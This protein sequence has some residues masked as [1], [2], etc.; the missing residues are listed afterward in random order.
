MRWAILCG[1]LALGTAAIAVADEPVTLHVNPSVSVAP[2]TVGIRVRVP[3]EADNRA[4]EIVLDSENFYRSSRLELDGDRAPLV[5][6]LRVGSLP[7]GTY[8]V[9]AAVMGVDG[10]RRGL[11]RKS[12]EV[13]GSLQSVR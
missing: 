7:A 6:T 8:V 13:M 3:P 2:A 9:T 5:S 1:G 10:A 11:A 4:L 12:V